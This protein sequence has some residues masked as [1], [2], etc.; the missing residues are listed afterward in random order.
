MSLELVNE[1]GD[2][3]RE[4]QR[5][6]EITLAPGAEL[7]PTVAAAL[8]R[9][10]IG[11]GG[12][13]SPRELRKKAK[14]ALSGM[15][16]S[17]ELDAFVVCVI[18]ELIVG[19]DLLE[20]PALLTD[21]D[22][23][24]CVMLFGAPPTFLRYGENIRI[25]GIA[26]DDA[27]F[28]P[29]SVHAQLLSRGGGRFIQGC[30]DE[31]VDLLHGQG[32]REIAISRWIG[33]GREESSS[34]FIQRIIDRLKSKGR[35]ES[36]ASTEWLSPRSHSGVSYRARWTSHPPE[37]AGHYIARA[38]QEFG[39]PRW[40]FIAWQPGQTPR[41]LDLPVQGE[42]D[43]RGCDLAWRLQLALDAARGKAARYRSTTHEEQVRLD[44]DF[45]I[46]LLQRRQ[47]DYLG[48]TATGSG[49]TLLVPRAEIS[50]AE[51]I[52][53]SIWFIRSGE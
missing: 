52:L 33:G 38:P 28:L 42:R 39:A 14:A 45:P 18:D 50:N 22:E 43:D 20:L 26:P 51:T 6:L 40:Y 35:T 13:Y 5:A 11:I 46:P 49:F 4:I 9:R 1:R 25:F 47:L 36:L 31:V 29:D 53:E 41:I 10:L 19:G 17:E 7:L 21:G 8:V 44:V 24:S 27:R 37:E 34:E 48:S 3:L 32:L 16:S 2:A 15:V 23:N 12:P 30:S